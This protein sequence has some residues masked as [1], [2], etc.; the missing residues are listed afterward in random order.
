MRL[1]LLIS[2]SDMFCGDIWASVQTLVLLQMTLN[3]YNEKQQFNLLK[4]APCIIS[5]LTR[6]G[7]ISLYFSQHVSSLKNLRSKHRKQSS[8]RRKV[9]EGSQSKHE[10]VAVNAESFITTRKTKALQTCLTSM[11]YTSE[12]K[13][14]TCKGRTCSLEY[15]ISH[16]IKHF[17]QQTPHY[18]L[19]PD[20]YLFIYFYIYCL[21]GGEGIVS[22]KWKEMITIKYAT[23]PAKLCISP[24]HS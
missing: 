19:E 8:E 17:T 21:F 14:V 7:S 23:I 22:C 15:T 3:P 10:V 5:Q 24:L 11:Y 6:E 16:I 1:N 13:P 9:R 20:F 12:R 18:G 2:L 4:H